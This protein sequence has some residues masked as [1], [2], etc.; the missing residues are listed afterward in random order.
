MFRDR[1]S[2]F[3]VLGHRIPDLPV[4]LFNVYPASKYALTAITQTIRQEL[5]FQRANIKLTVRTISINCIYFFLYLFLATNLFS[6]NQKIDKNVHTIITKKN[7]IV[8]YSWCFIFH[9]NL[10]SQPIECNQLGEY[11][12]SIAV[13]PM[14]SFNENY[15]ILRFCAGFNAYGQSNLLFYLLE[16]WSLIFN[17]LDSNM[18]CNRFQFMWVGFWF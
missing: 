9:L 6:I 2:F 5:A 8:W 14:V 18:E 3:S 17:L 15:E 10:N 12:N 13:Y 16:L 11:L 1:F 4:P 7:A